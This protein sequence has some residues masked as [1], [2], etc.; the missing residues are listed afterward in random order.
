M[1]QKI[2]FSVCSLIA[3]SNMK[4][5]YTFLGYLVEFNSDFILTDISF[6]VVWT[7]IEKWQMFTEITKTQSYVYVPD[8]IMEICSMNLGW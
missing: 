1:Y 8:M 2:L 4:G 7:I 3:N 6:I 5:L